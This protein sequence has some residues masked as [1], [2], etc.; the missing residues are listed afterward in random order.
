MSFQQGLSGLN[1]A[2]RNL[3]VIGHNIANTSTVGFKSSQAQF[4]D[5]YA[6]SL[7][8]VGGLQVG[9][10]AKIADVAQS[11]TQ[12]N[13]SATGNTLDLALTG[14]GFFQVSKGG[15]TSYTRNGQFH[16]DDQGFLVDSSLARVQGYSATNGVLATSPGSDLQ[17]VITTGKPSAT[18]N[19]ALSLNVN[20][21]A[22]TPAAFADATPPT[23]FN[24]TTSVNVFDSLG[25]EHTL[26]LYY[27]K[28]VA[29]GADMGW[30]MFAYMDGAPTN[31][32]VGSPGALTFPVATGQLT[33]ATTAH[34]VT[35]NF[36]VG[37]V[38]SPF[39]IDLDLTGTSMFADDF[40]VNSLTQDGFSTGDLAGLAVTKDG[41]VQAQYTNGEALTIG[42]LSLTSFINPNGMLSVGD[43]HWIA[44]P[45]AG[46]AN[47]Q[48]PNSGLLGLI[49]SGAVEESNVDL[50]AELVNL[51]IAQRMYQANA[52]TIKA[53]DQILQTLVNLR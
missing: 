5:V 23:G 50:T 29:A 17:V 45:D 48:Q 31:L 10:G 28:D 18:A 33:P 1:G 44:T 22:I 24:H 46:T 51:I 26:G 15:V 41:I 14:E 52:Q 36:S 30:E 42:Q 16:L 4:A 12:G 6:T 11:F 53:Q 35:G 38:S 13:I 21:D 37:G 2:A 39:S 40:G 8:G 3:D 20:A 9:I 32:A 25:G 43:N 19:V 7:F 34:T 27:R 49:Q 47:T